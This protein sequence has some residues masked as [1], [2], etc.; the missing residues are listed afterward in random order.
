[1]VMPGAMLFRKSGGNMFIGGSEGQN[2]V[3]KGKWM[4]LEGLQEEFAKILGGFL[5]V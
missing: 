2:E 4:G 1:M 3:S 5:R